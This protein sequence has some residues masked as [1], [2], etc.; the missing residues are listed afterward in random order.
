[1]TLHDAV[2]VPRAINLTSRAR[3]YLRC[4]DDWKAP[5]EIVALLGDNPQATINDV[6]RML[7]RLA[8]K[9]LVYHSRANNTYRITID[10]RAVLAAKQE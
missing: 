4:V 8:A 3:L 9:G 2:F 6:N 1:M 7:G 5:Y 10:G